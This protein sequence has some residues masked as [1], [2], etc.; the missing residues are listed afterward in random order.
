MNCTICNS[1]I[2]KT[3]KAIYD[4]RFGLDKIFDIGRCIN[5]GVTVTFPSPSFEDLKT[6]YETYYNFGSKEETIYTRLREHL[7]ASPLY[8]FWL[9]IDGDIAFHNIKGSGRLLDIGCN[10][11]RGLNLYRQ[12]GFDAEGLELNELAAAEGKKKGFKVYTNPVETFCP[13]E[14]YDVVVLSNVLEHALKPTEML[15]H[16][17]RILKPDGQVWISCPNLESWQCKLFGKY[18]INWHVPFHIVHFSQHILV[19]TLK[20]SHFKIQDMRQ[21]SPSLWIAYSL[22]TSL[23]AKPGQPTKQ[24]RNPFLV[25]AFMILARGILFPILWLGNRM[26]YG[27]CLVVVAQKCKLNL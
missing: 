13:T 10:E 1:D 23:F 3:N 26:G 16:I 2:N 8:R 20:A 6:L 24:L 9:A 21:A 25:A 12:N 7:F 22:I 4:T 14:P 5:C 15:D 17:F 11:G 19:K 18:W 27:D